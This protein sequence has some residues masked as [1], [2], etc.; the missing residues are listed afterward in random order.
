[1]SDR[2]S[3]RRE[4]AARPQVP[5]LDRLM[6]ESPDEMRE[7]QPSPSQAMEALR[8]SIRRDLEAL[9]NARRRWR[10]LP[11]GLAELPKSPLGYGVP[12]C[13]AGGINEPRRREWLR[14][15]VEDTI[16][17]FEPRF[18]RVQVSLQD[19]RNKLDPT[20][21]L[22]IDAL[23]HADPAPEPVAFDTTLDPSTADVVVRA[24][25]DV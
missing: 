13:T 25:D 9:L 4:G 7:V 21:R 2:P 24:R 11:P 20:L 1:M 3:G 5:L 8:R 10:S 16:R 15:E 22:R 19:S 17:R 14:R 18:A 23:L 12:D 6:D